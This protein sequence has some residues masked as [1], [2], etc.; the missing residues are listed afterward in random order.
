MLAATNPTGGLQPKA[1][2]EAEPRFGDF[3]YS[4]QRI[5]EPTAE[6]FQDSQTMIRTK[7]GARIPAAHLAAWGLGS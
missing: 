4:N 2:A 6:A 5:F 7:G 1:P 3:R